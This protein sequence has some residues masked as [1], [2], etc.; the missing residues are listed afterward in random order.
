[1]NERFNRT[2]HVAEALDRAITRLTWD[3]QLKDIFLALD[4]AEK[5][6]EPKRSLELRRII[7][8]GLEVL[9]GVKMPAEKG[10]R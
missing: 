10:T 7:D 6:P 1:M 9:E 2:V 3:Q 4:E 5:L 8:A